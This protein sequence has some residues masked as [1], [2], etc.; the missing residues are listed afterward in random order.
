MAPRSTMLGFFLRIILVA[1]AVRVVG[2]LMRALIGLPRHQ[3]E[4]PLTAPPRKPLVDRASA[5]DVPFT[6]EPRES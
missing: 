6:E 5:I 2:G 1:L 3:P 4:T